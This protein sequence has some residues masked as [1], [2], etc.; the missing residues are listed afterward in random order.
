ML[1]MGARSKQN[2][3]QTIQTTS[4]YLVE[5]LVEVSPPIKIQYKCMRFGPKFKAELHGRKGCIV[6]G[7]LV[8]LSLS[9]SIPITKVTI[10]IVWLGI[11][12]AV[13]II[14]QR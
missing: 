3:T 8:T 1:S 9:I 10:G 5:R 13:Y 6:V 2:A 4:I 12:N 11:L 7:R 14:L